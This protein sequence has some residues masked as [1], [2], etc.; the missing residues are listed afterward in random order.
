MKVFPECYHCLAKLAFNAASLATTDEKIRDHAFLSAIEAL[1]SLFCESAISIT[2]STKIHEMIKQVTQ[3]ADP[4]RRIKDREIELAA[5]L[6]KEVEPMYR[7]GFVDKLKLSAFGNS[8][9]FFRPLDQ[10]KETEKNNKIVFAIDQTD[11]FHKKLQTARMALYLAD[12][13]GEVYFDAPLYEFMRQF[14]EVYYVVKSRPVQNDIT[15]EDLLRSGLEHKFPCVLETGTATPGILLDRASKTFLEAYEKADI[16]L[17]KGMGYYESLGESD[18]GDRIF[19]SLKAK[20]KPVADS[21]GVP[22]NSYIFMTKENK[23]KK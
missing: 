17:A 15:R 8:M 4:Y 12:N 19:Y 6:F 22:L 13:S 3:N 2:I 20:C 1:D 21:I 7:D 5:I 11:L 14:T 16:I 23:D 9:D 10:I 18:T